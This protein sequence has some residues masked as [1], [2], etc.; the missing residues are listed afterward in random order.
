MCVLV[1]MATNI[2]LYKEFL[3]VLSISKNE[4]Q[5]SSWSNVL[6]VIPRSL[7]H[8]VT[9]ES[10]KVVGFLISIN[11]FFFPSSLKHLLAYIWT[12]F[13]E[14]NWCCLIPDLKSD[15]IFADSDWMSLWLML[16]FGS[17]L[18]PITPMRIQLQLFVGW[19]FNL[20]YC[21]FIG[22]VWARNFN[23]IDML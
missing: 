23:W 21:E 9:G 12:S 22:M 17:I 6:A 14:R 2:I 15:N 4:Q 16:S 7:Y 5:N 1:F 18:K 13:S 20:G 10:N 8:W 19:V 3:E 11:V